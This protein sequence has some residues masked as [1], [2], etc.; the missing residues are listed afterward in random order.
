MTVA[1]EKAK[2]KATSIVE[3]EEMGARAK[4]SAVAKAYRAVEGKKQGYSVVVSGKNGATKGK[5]SG[6]KGRTKVVDPRLKKDTRAAKRSAKAKA[7]NGG[8]RK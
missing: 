3:T 1:L 4:A 7:K 6:K 5:K 8:R 2:R